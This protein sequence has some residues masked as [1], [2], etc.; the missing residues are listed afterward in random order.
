METQKELIKQFLLGEL[1]EER[2]QEVEERLLTDSEYRD[3]ILMTEGELVEDYL[4]ETLPPL[5][6]E[7]FE[8]HYL[9]APRQERNV[10][11][12]R[13]L[14][15][16]AQ[17]AK[18]LPSSKANWLQSLSNFFWPRSQNM[19]FATVS[20]AIVAI[21][22]AVV[23]FN[24]WRSAT[25]RAELQAEVVRLNTPENILPA[26]DTVPAVTL[27]P[28]SLRENGA[29]PRLAIS[30]AA[31]VVQLRVPTAANTYQSYNFEVSP[32]RGEQLIQFELNPQP[33]GNTLLLQLPARILKPNDYVLTMRGMRTDGVTEDVGE[34]AFR[35]VQQ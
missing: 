32:I 13:I 26:S 6:R 31:E 28:F 19:R 16:G 21:V 1:S 29:L 15:K 23:I 17:A 11:L 20:L 35:V 34:Y 24:A 27:L 5:D 30:P 33:A 2:R 9:T 8:K 22:A 18:P 10:K 4:T 7:N 14:L 25:Q 3:E 12:T